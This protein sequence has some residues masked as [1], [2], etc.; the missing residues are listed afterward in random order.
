M[1]R[2][3]KRGHRNERVKS[4]KLRQ[5]RRR[6][7]T[8]QDKTKQI[9]SRSVLGRQTWWSHNWILPT[10]L[11]SGGF[12]INEL[13]LYICICTGARSQSL[14][15]GNN[16]R[17]LCRNDT[18]SHLSASLNLV[19]ALSRCSQTHQSDS[20]GPHLVRSSHAGWPGAAVR[21]NGWIYPI[22]DKR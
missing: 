1:V 3:G 22:S 18:P 12:K 19:W 11:L 5:K 20:C 2:W 9:I 4:K 15:I 14:Q 7:R 10:N 6:T 21:I 13:V 8:R 17:L 16:D